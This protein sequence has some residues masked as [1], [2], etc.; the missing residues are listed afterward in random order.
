MMIDL[1]Q[2][3]SYHYI[4]LKYNL[5]YYFSSVHKTNVIQKTINIK[6]QV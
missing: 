4:H 6:Y 3:P 2:I 1:I 5:V